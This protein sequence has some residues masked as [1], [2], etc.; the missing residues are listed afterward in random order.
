M[1]HGAGIFT[2]MCPKNHKKMWV[3]I[4]HIPASWG[5]WE[6]IVSHQLQVLWTPFHVAY[7]SPVS[8][9]GTS[10]P[11]TMDLSIVWLPGVRFQFSQ[12]NQSN[13]REIIMKSSINGSVFPF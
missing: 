8:L 9:E 10:S 11:E 7:A 3:N 12:T 2:N 5:I 6:F 4:Y 1:L 13:E